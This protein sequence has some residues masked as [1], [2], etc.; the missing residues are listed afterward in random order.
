MVALRSLLLGIFR[1]WNRTR[2]RSPWDLQCKSASDAAPWPQQTDICFFLS[3]P[4]APVPFRTSRRSPRTRSSRPSR[5]VQSTVQS[6]TLQQTRRK[7]GSVPCICPSLAWP[8]SQPRHPSHRLQALRPP[9]RQQTRLDFADSIARQ[10][11]DHVQDTAQS[12]RRRSH[13]QTTPPTRPKTYGSDD[14]HTSRPTHPTWRTSSMTR[15][16]CPPRSTR[17]TRLRR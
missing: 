9:P 1:A 11:D 15:S 4:P 14:R 17:S 3:Q 8:A 5:S 2:A 6:R 13:P 7:V 10:P 12:C 16:R